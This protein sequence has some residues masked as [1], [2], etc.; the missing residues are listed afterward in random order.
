MGGTDAARSEDSTS[1]RCC[2]REAHRRPG[3]HSRTMISIIQATRIDR[4]IYAYCAANIQKGVP[5]IRIMDITEKPKL[6]DV[7]RFDE[8]S[9]SLSLSTHAVPL[10]FFHLSV[11][12]SK[13]F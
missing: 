8:A 9:Y 2:F 6:S 12:F 3:F 10:F 5:E 11:F 1:G 7:I 13:Y 4:D